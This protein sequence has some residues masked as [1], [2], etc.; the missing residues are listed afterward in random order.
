[1]LIPVLANTASTPD[2]GSIIGQIASGGAAGAI[3]TAIVG[4]IKTKA[5]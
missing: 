5:A 4:A 2:I 3:L 1:M